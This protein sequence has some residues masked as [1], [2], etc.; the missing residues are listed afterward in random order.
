MTILLQVKFTN[1]HYLVNVFL[2]LET[3]MELVPVEHCL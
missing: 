1:K 3:W 2:L